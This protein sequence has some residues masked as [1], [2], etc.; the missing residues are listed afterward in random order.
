[1]TSTKSRKY[2]LYSNTWDSKIMSPRVL[3]TQN[4]H[5][6]GSKNAGR[7]ML[8]E[9]K[10]S[11]LEEIIPINT[12]KDKCS[13]FMPNGL[14]ICLT[15]FHHKLL[16]RYKNRTMQTNYTMVTGTIQWRISVDRPLSSMSI[17]LSTCF[18]WSAWGWLPGGELQ[19]H[20]HASR[21]WQFTRSANTRSLNLRMTN[22]QLNCNS[23]GQQSQNGR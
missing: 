16:T 22:P 1:M 13:K 7:A 20:R 6:H 12:C 18:E 5:P 4:Q 23:T 15:G 11:D 21:S 8:I 2:N 9:P 17:A 19:V 3:H 14:Q 10:Y